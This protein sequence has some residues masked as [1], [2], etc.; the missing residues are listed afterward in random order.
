MFVDFH[1]PRLKNHDLGASSMD[2]PPKRMLRAP[3][4]S[5][6]VVMDEDYSVT[7]SDTVYIYIYMYMYGHRP[8]M[9][10]PQ[11]P[12]RNIAMIMFRYANIYI[13]S[14]TIQIP[15][16]NKQYVY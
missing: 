1:H 11:G 6:V 16:R 13:L 10:L 3:C 12:L 9:D 7:I 5:P 8:Q 4:Q 2:S 15:W 14:K